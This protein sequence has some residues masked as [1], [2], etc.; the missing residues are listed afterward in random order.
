MMVGFSLQKVK[1]LHVTQRKQFLM[2]G[3]GRTMLGFTSQ[4]SFDYVSS[5]DHLEMAIDSNN[6]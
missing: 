4:L 2:I 5:D 3:L 6:S 1:W